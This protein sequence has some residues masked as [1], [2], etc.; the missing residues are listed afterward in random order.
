MNANGDSS[1]FQTFW[2]SYALTPKSSR[3]TTTK[4]DSLAAE[5]ETAKAMV[6]PLKQP[7]LTTSHRP[8]PSTSETPATNP[9]GQVFNSSLSHANLERQLLAAQATTSELETKLRE[10]ELLIER[11]ERDR[12]YFADRER[13][14]RE[15]KEQERIRWTRRLRFILIFHARATR[16]LDPAR[17]ADAHQLPL[18]R[19]LRRR[20]GLEW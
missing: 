5:L 17:F 4:R 6:E 3:S 9:I 20:Y 12:R 16:N 11:L 13:E 15:E 2:R 18:S 14:E 19:I 7:T 8:L 10:K 1:I